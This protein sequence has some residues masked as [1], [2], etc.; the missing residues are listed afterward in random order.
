MGKL[1]RP[2]HVDPFHVLSL[3]SE[4]PTQMLREYSLLICC[5][6]WIKAAL[7]GSA[8]HADAEIG[9]GE[10]GTN[11]LAHD[12]LENAELDFAPNSVGLDQMVLWRSFSSSL[13][14][15]DNCELPDRDHVKPI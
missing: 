13:A 11:R 2:E 14:F 8:L 9:G 12:G 1:D 7:S 5:Q 6:A 15:P 3:S 10:R 4:E